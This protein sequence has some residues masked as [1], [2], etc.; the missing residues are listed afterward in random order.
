M[1]IFVIAN[2]SFLRDWRNCT[3]VLLEASRDSVSA[4]DGSRSRKQHLKEKKNSEKYVKGPHLK[5]IV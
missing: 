5:S 3:H 2:V 1:R 4:F